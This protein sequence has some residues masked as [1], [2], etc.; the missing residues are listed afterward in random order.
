MI[1]ETEN[2][3]RKIQLGDEQAF[4]KVFVSYYNRLCL[5]AENFISDPS[6]AEDIVQDVFFYIWDKRDNLH[7]NTSLES[8]IYRA[9]HNHCIQILRHQKAEEKYNQ[10]TL[11]KLREAELLYPAMLN[12]NLNAAYSREFSQLLKNA[13]NKLPD[14]TREIFLYSRK[15]KLKNQEI[16]K[17]LGMSEKNVEYHISK[18]LQ[19][20]SEELKNYTFCLFLFL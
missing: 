16:S 18:A 13:I 3:I 8:Y 17:E 15:L 11:Y 5:Y 4:K 6:L 9:V 14:K 1:Q 7:I 10:N 19:I 12:D 20:L 2:I